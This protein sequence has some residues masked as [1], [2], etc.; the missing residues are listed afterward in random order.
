MAQ[1]RK[2]TEKETKMYQSIYLDNLILLNGLYTLVEQHLT[3]NH[4]EIEIS[5]WDYYRRKWLEEDEEFKLR[6]ETIRSN[7]VHMVENEMFR[8]IREG[9]TSMIRFFLERKGDYTE[10]KETKIDIN[11]P[12]KIN[13]VNPENE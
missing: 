12:I 6:F 9:D 11:A 4:P 8:K 10:K 7:V 5:K 1:G 3:D 2:L 13:I